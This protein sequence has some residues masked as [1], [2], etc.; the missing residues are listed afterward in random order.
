MSTTPFTPAD[1]QSSDSLGQSMKGWFLEYAS[2]VA[3]DRAIPH[4]AD[5]LK[6]VQRRI[7]HV[8]HLMEDGR[9]NKNASI[10]GESTKY[11][12][13]GD[14]SI[15]DALVHLGQKQLCIDTQGNWGSLYTGHGAAA[16]RYIEARLTAFA[17]E[18]VFNPLTTEWG[19]T[20][21]G[22]KREP[23]ALPTKFPLL[24]DQGAEGIAVGLACRILPHNF[25]D[26][27]D[28]QI[29]VL[30]NKSFTL[31]P[32]FPTGGI[33]DATA[34][35]DGQRGGRVISR[36]HISKGKANQGN[37]LIISSVPYGITTDVL[38]ESILSAHSKGKLQVAH[39][40]DNTA[41]TVAVHV[42]F[43]KGQDLEAA[44]NALYAYTKCQVSLPVYACVLDI[45][46]PKF[47]SITEIVEHSAHQAERLCKQEL[48][49]E[50]SHL[51]TQHTGLLLE[52]IFIEQRVYRK[53]EKCSDEETM[54]K[55]VRRALRPHIRAFLDPLPDEHLKKLLQIPVRRISKFDAEKT[56]IQLQGLK[57]QMAV[58]E[59]HLSDVRGYTVAYLRQIKKKY[60][61]D[62]P[63]LTELKVLAPVSLQTAALTNQHLYF[64]TDAGFVGTALKGAPELAMC[65]EV[66]DI[67]AIRKN[68]VLCISRV[69]PKVY[70]GQSPLYCQ[71]WDKTSEETHAMV[72]T[73]GETGRT[74]I[75][76]FTVG[77]ITRNKEYPLVS[78]HPKTQI[79]WYET[80][81]PN[82]KL[83]NLTVK[84]QTGQKL[85]KRVLTLQGGDFNLT[86]RGARGSLVSKFA[87][88]EVTA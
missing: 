78:N 48:T 30:R 76:H 17:K 74:Y 16:P 6:P 26:I 69:A 70:V 88:K 22:R 37:L 80:I 86:S 82:A 68:G 58:L 63:R 18:V 79:H 33:A 43:P 73:D 1:I 11:H 38:K 15:R 72:Y 7:L 83:P 71:L 42:K 40:E 35:N 59:G 52:K 4:L 62:Y 14:A 56:D 51:Q 66:D 27:I 53:L 25:N 84:L 44:K 65:S 57:E 28:A 50:L 85:K 3:T 47:V 24:L 39:I 9:Y 67:M 2:Y 8:M 54:G 81:L 5:G 75:K 41:A 12:P 10:I 45:D 77:G 49:L 19:K 36:A 60:G 23:I 61:K 29:A 55:T 64:N 31:L 20:Y 21:D 87:V 34:Y 32:D 13:H 46:Q